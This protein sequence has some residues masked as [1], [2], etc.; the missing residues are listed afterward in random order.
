M[1]EGELSC[2]Q[3][4]F[5]IQAYKFQQR[6]GFFRHLCWKSG[7]HGEQTF[8][9]VGHAGLHVLHA[10]HLAVDAGLLKGAQEAHTG[11]FRDTQL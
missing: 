11:N 3:M 1:T 10:V 5:Y 8:V 7:E 6:F 4:A 2:A 9:D